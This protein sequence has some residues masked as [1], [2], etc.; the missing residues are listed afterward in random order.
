MSTRYV[1]RE[2]LTTSMGKLALLMP[3][4]A[5]LSHCGNAS[6]TNDGSDEGFTITSSLASG[7]T[8]AIFLLLSDVASP[9]STG[10]TYQSTTS[11]NHFHLVV[12]TQAQLTS[13]DEGAVVTVTS[14]VSD[15]HQHA[16][17]IQ[18]P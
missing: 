7:H 12:V 6:T 15:G 5:V 3:A 10:L 16:F 4:A 1:R 13:I 8:H 17:S 9:P 18:K 2:F 11:S 14:S